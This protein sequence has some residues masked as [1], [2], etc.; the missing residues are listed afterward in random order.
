M[1]R[2]EFTAEDFLKETTN[3]SDICGGC[4]FFNLKTGECRE[5]KIEVTFKTPKC[6][7]WRYFA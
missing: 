6:D 1:E 4:R 2:K 5:K 7:K 3:L